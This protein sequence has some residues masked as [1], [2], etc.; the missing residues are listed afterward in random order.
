M[1]F[2]IELLL[3]F[4]NGYFDNVLDFYNMTLV[5]NNWKNL[6]KYHINLLKI[7]NIFNKIH[8]NWVNKCIL[9]V[10]DVK[11]QV[12][13]AFAIPRLQ[14]ENLNEFTGFNTTLQDMKK[15]KNIKKFVK[16]KINYCKCNNKNKWTRGSNYGR[17]FFRFC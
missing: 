16:K 7:Y 14:I 13:H 9:D 1:D 11:S 10:I 4:K 12:Y 15:W 5:C 2:I 8:I 3:S 17:I 6:L